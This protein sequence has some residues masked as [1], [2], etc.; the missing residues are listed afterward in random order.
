MLG[1]HVN[2]QLKRGVKIITCDPQKRLIEAET[3]NGEVITVNAYNY[4]PSFRWPKSGEKWMVGE[5]NGSWYLEGIYETQGT[6]GSTTQ[7]EPGDVVLSA[8][9]GRVLLNEEGKLTQL[10][11]EEE[12]RVTGYEEN[13]AAEG[14]Q[15]AHQ[16]T[17]GEI[18]KQFNIP[19]S[20]KARFILI[21]F[22]IKVAEN[23]GEVI[24]EDK[25]IGIVERSG[26]VGALY[27]TTLTVVI[28]PNQKCVIS[29]TA[30]QTE[31]GKEVGE[32]IIDHLWES[33]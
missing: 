10:K 8:S 19:V 14:F 4:T 13:F 29:G 1:D 11:S 26:S 27:R 5:E 23:F 2:L 31:E 25:S 32:V 20:S 33:I 22:G 30:N 24:L 6:E 28:P 7:A 9:S 17:K 3:R 15:L 12:L 21:T 16:F 18:K